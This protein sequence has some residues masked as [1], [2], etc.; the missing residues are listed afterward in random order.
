MKTKYYRNIEREINR[1]FYE[2]IYRPL[3]RV[4]EVPKKEIVNAGDTALSKAIT[5]GR[6][7][8]RDGS[9][10]GKFNSSIS[11]ELV[12]IGAKYNKTTKAWVFGGVMPVEVSMASA[13]A[14]LE[15]TRL[16]ARTMT[17]LESVNAGIIDKMSSIPDDIND[18]LS[19]MDKDFAKTTK[20]ISISANLTQEQKNVIA[21]EW[22]QNMDKHI[23]GWVDDNVIKLR[24]VVEKN[25]L[26]GG[27]SS[28]LVKA[29]KDN[30]GTS[31]AKAKFLAKQETS[32]LMSKFREERYKSIGITKYRWSISNIRTR[33]DHEDL[34]GRVFTWD[35]PP[36]TNKKTGARNN[37]GEDFG[38][39][40]VAVPLI[41]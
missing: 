3:I 5:S 6:V 11:R 15:Y 31:K 20:G 13:V 24:E 27:R 26:A 25:T 18:A 23:K 41:E 10:H 8:Y 2:V 1:L 39:N 21:A 4:L 34:D 38:C 17:V 14:V 16:T 7:W 32:L 9:F 12:K 30:Y 33:P 37:A 28:S 35:N 36:I 40:C 19:F 29:I 22:S